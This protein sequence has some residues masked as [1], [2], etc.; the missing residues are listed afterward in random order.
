MKNIII[1]ILLNI[2]YILSY[3]Q[4]NRIN[5]EDV[6]CNVDTF[7]MMILINQNVE[8][9]NDTI[10]IRKI[11]VLDD[12]YFFSF[13]ETELETGVSYDVFNIQNEEYK[14]YFTQLPIVNLHT[15]NTIVDEPRVSAHFSLCETNE[16]YIE[17][18]IGI[19]IRGGSS[20]SHPKK[21]FRIEFLDDTINKKTVD[22]SLLGMR[23][24]DDWNLQAM[25]NEPLRLRS[26]VNFAL[27]DKID[28]LYYMRQEPS[29]N[30]G[31]EQEYIELFLNDEYQGIYTLSERIDRKQLQLKKNKGSYLRGELYKGVSWGASTY[32]SIPNFNNT[33]ELW[34]GFKYEYPSDTTIWDNLY[35]YIDFVI[36]DDSLSFY[37]K[38]T[39]KLCLENAVNYF[40]FLNTLRATDNTGKNLYLAR[41]NTNEPYFFVPW[42]LDGTFGTIWNGSKVNITNDILT[43][44]LYNRL[45]LDTKSDG[46]KYSLNRR[47]KELRENTITVDSILSMFNSEFD[48]L[49]KNGA[50]KREL[51]VWKECTFIDMNNLD[52]TKSWLEDRL[53]FLDKEWGDSSTFTGIGNIQV[54]TE[55]PIVF[56]NPTSNY[57]KFQSSRKV[58]KISIFNNIGVI[59]KNTYPEDSSGTI[60]IH[61]L[62]S[63]LYIAVFKLDSGESKVTRF[64]INE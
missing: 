1:L 56:P 32:T 29:A 44:G 38:Y 53:N 3:S 18:D 36:N 33:N 11:Q 43:N 5:V 37:P 12:D 28:N 15:N 59:Q 40:I 31:I 46:F 57:L 42:D 2:F 14:L 60:E 39:E 6:Y 49:T 50:Y 20:K 8:E 9:I 61:N 51:E 25:Y 7:N 34:S 54:A 26:K 62:N 19:E 22:V 24:D 17:S 10:P 4:E 16:N 30:N 27:W 55:S 35:E 47:W 48:Y 64:I 41:Y 58:I 63:G 45:L 52:Y 21:S 13:P 23:S